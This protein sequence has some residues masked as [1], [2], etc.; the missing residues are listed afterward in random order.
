MRSPEPSTI[1]IPMGFV[2]LGISLYSLIIW[3]AEESPALGY[4][5]V[6]AIV[7]RLAGLSVFLVVSLSSF[8]GNRRTN[9]KDSA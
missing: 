9:A 5:F 2:L 8:Y 1:W 4:A 6:G 7:A 3:A